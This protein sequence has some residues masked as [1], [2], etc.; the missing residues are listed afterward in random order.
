LSIGLQFSEESAASIFKAED[1][2]ET[3]I[4]MVPSR[5]QSTDH[6]KTFHFVLLAL[7]RNAPDGLNKDASAF[8]FR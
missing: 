4:F 7:M 6:E 8:L 1:F 3:V 2:Y 5:F